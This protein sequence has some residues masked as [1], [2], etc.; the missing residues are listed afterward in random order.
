LPAGRK[1]RT[2]AILVALNA[3]QVGRIDAV[4]SKLTV[5]REDL[6]QI[7][8]PEL[9]GT[10]QEAEASL[11]RGDAANFRRLVS[12]VVSRLGHLK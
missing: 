8:E 10:L 7:D 4:L 9:A 6:R 3:I 1:E 5:A 12:Q 2:G 11:T